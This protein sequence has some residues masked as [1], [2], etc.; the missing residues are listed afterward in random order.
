LGAAAPLVGSE[1]WFGI[2]DLEFVIFLGFGILGF[3]ISAVGG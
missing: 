3:G 1:G 2:C